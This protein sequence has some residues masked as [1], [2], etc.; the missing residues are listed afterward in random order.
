M[1]TMKKK[2][3]MMRTTITEFMRVLGTVR[4]AM[5]IEK[6]DNGEEGKTSLIGS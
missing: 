5:T 3:T 1:K 2:T 6:K 4:G